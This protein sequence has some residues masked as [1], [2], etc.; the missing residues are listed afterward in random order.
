MIAS[1]YSMIGLTIYFLILIKLI[2]R[3]S[4]YKGLFSITGT[5]PVESRLKQLTHGNE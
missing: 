3:L 5:M 4:F 1:D 2:Q